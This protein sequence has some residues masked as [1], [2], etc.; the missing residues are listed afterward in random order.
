MRKDRK[1]SNWKEPYRGQQDI[2]AV[3]KQQDHQQRTPQTK[4]FWHNVKKMTS[5]AE[6]FSSFYKKHTDKNTAS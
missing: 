3:P 4:K 6:V 1:D 5:I 2:E